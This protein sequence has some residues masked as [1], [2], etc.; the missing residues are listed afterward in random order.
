MVK[1]IERRVDIELV[2]VLACIAIVYFHSGV[3]T[4]AMRSFAYSGLVVF[5]IISVCYLS[6][7]SSI[8][9]VARP[10]AAKLLAPY[11]IWS[12]VFLALYTVI[13]GK[14]ISDYVKLQTLFAGT[15]IH[16]WYLPFAYLV[17]LFSILIKQKIPSN[18]LS[19]IAGVSFLVWISLSLEWRGMVQST[20]LPIPQYAHAFGAVLLGLWVSGFRGWINGMI[21]AFSMFLSLYI[22]VYKDTGVGVV[23]FVGMLFCL[24]LMFG[25]SINRYLQH[26]K[27]F[28][29]FVAPLT[30]GIYIVHPI[31]LA[32]LSKVG[33]SEAAWGPL[34]VFLGSAVFVYF[35]QRLLPKKISSIVLP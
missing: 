3:L 33:I 18:I 4:G 1:S 24:L 7:Q 26:I 30:Y 27:G 34:L 23:Y 29:F 19:L 11:V 6:S 21:F 9:K 5:I 8:K 22:A 12:F 15:S 10:M 20:P 28:V 2:R 13:V 16:L 32:V 31:G 14:P 25:T 35:G 17:L